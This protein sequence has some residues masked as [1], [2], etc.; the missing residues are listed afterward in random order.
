VA[1][2]AYTVDLVFQHGRLTGTVADEAVDL[3]AVIPNSH[4]SAVGRMG[5]SSV[6]AMWDVAS[7]YNM[8]EQPASL[9][10]KFGS[11]EVRLS[12][13]IR[14]RDPRMPIFVG[15]DVVG[16]VLG[17]RVAVRVA[18]GREFTCSVFIDGQVGDLAIDLAAAVSSDLESGEAQGTI[19]G[20]AVRLEASRLPEDRAGRSVRGDWAGPSSICLMSAASLLYFM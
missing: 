20:H 19:G 15:A 14:L 8:A 16:D 1:I 5:G 13:T 18:P 3:E 10:A 4:S 12:T 17:D 2:G 6:T 9:V 7:N 11:G